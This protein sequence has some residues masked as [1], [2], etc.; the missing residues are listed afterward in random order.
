MSR[1]RTINDSFWRDHVVSDL[2]QEDRATLVYLL[3]SPSSNIIG[4]YVVV[5]RIASAEM[6]WTPEQ[7][8]V[9]IKRLQKKGL[10]LH[11]Q[12]TGW[13]WIKVWWQHNSLRAAF[14]GKMRENT[15]KQI[16][17][18]P[19]EWMDDYL[20]DLAA[21]GIDVPPPPQRR[22]GAAPASPHRHPDAAPP[23]NSTFTFTCSSPRRRV[24]EH[25]AGLRAAITP[26]PESSKG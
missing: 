25:L 26:Q 18:M 10:I 11:K 12:E 20:A 13:L 17:A 8:L 7:L 23:T 22:P 6:G 5:P 2:S 1:Q 19:S 3:T 14:A 15:L 21:Q 24:G 16:F 9:V 4:V